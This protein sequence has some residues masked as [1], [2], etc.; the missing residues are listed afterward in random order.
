MHQTKSMN[1]KQI[2]IR[3]HHKKLMKKNRKQINIKFGTK[4][5]YLIAEFALMNWLK[6]PNIQYC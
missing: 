1:N 4:K 3:T 5:D 6:F 2:K